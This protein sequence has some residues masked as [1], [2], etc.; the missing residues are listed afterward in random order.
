MRGRRRCTRCS[1][2]RRTEISSE[3][4]GSSLHRCDLTERDLRLLHAGRRI[5]AIGWD[6]VGA[7]AEHDRISAFR[8][9]TPQ[10]ESA[11]PATA[12]ERHPGNSLADAFGDERLDLGL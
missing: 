1:D 5:V 2:R 3:P 6:R 9:I 10:I 7:L 4:F 12:R 8:I 11:E